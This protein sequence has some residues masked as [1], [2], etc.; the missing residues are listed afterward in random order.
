MHG[1][2]QGRTDAQIL[3][4]PE[5]PAYAD[6]DYK[7]KDREG[8]DADGYHG[9]CMHCGLPF[10][11]A[12]ELWTKP[13]TAEWFCSDECAGEKKHD[14]MMLRAYEAKADKERE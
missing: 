2:R 12:T 1:V 14:D 8:E 6:H 10:H 9:G 3:A 5:G 13:G 7:V 11:A 4:A